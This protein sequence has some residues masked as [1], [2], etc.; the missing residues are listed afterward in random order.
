MNELY[1]R[2]LQ[3]GIQEEEEA[4]KFDKLKAIRE[5]IARNK[6]LWRIREEGNIHHGKSSSF[7]SYT[8]KTPPNIYHTGRPPMLGGALKPSYRVV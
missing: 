1:E 6:W 8:R 4:E 5:T 3:E 2:L 7:L